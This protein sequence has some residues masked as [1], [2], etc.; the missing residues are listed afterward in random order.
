MG[1]APAVHWLRFWASTAGGVG[2]VPGPGTKITGSTVR[3]KKRGRNGEKSVDGTLKPTS[4]P[5]E[6]VTTSTQATAVE[7]LLS[8]MQLLES[9][10]W[11]MKA[12]WAMFPVSWLRRSRE[13]LFAHH[14]GPWKCQSPLDL[15][16]AMAGITASEFHRCFFKMCYQ[17]NFEL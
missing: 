3:P 8:E 6:T 5:R 10:L 1:N 2:L 17:P 7:A 16:W 14:P 13:G 12:A 15:T 9:K 11:L 4:L